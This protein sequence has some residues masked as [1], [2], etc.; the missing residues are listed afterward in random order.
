MYEQDHRPTYSEI[1]DTYN[2]VAKKR[3]WYIIKSDG[4]IKNYTRRLNI[5]K[6]VGVAEQKEFINQP[7]RH[8]FIGELAELCKCSR[9]TVRLA[10]YENQ[11]GEKSELV[12]KVYKSR[13]SNEI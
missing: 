13:Y 9:H 4:T 1:R 8:G 10:I 3:G 5:Y 12:R 2:I 11:S 6:P 7:P